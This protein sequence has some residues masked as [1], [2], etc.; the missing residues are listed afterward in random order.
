LNNGFAFTSI[1]AIKD[2]PANSTIDII[3]AVLEISGTTQIKMKSGDTKDRL[4]ITVGDDSGCSV[5]ITVWGNI[6]NKLTSMMRLGDVVAFKQ[7]RVSDYQGKSLNASSDEKDF[8]NS[9]KHPRAL[10]L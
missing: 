8:V 9:V 5:P 6:A 2:L 1:A 7:C 10:Q 3:G 4:N